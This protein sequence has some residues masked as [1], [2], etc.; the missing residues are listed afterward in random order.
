MDKLFKVLVGLAALAAACSPDR[1]Q[2][3]LGVKPAFEEQSNPP[4]DDCNPMGDPRPE[5]NPEPPPPQYMTYEVW[6]DS[7]P[8]DL[9]LSAS[10]YEE[11]PESAP[12][13]RWITGL[14]QAQARDPHSGHWYSFPSTGTWTIDWVASIPYLSSSQAIYNWPQGGGDGSW[15][16]YNLSLQAG[17]AKIWVTKA[18]GFCPAPNS[19][20]FFLFYGVRV[21]DP[22]IRRPGDG[23]GAGGTPT[24]GG[25]TD[26]SDCRDEWII[27]EINYGDGTGWHTWWE[28]WARV[29]G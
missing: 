26:P 15:P 3:P 23:G 2:E 28:G 17:G 18:R 8:V 13:P 27:I 7:I 16:A 4:P 20:Q 6:V 29:C 9:Q 21:E 25:G 14:V 22:N 5:C 12:C 24:G 1:V 10:S 19:V 11:D